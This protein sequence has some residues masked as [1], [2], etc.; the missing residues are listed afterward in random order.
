MIVLGIDTATPKAGIA[1]VRSGRTLAS[2]F[3]DGDK[4]HSETLLAS[5]VSLIDKVGITLGE[6]DLL[7]LGLGPGAFTA[8]R[9]GVTTVKALS[10]SLAVPVVGISTLDVLAKGVLGYEGGYKGLVA[11][12]ID[13]RK[14]EVYTALFRA[15]GKGGIERVGDYLNLTPEELFNSIESDI[16]VLGNG[17]SVL[18]ENFKGNI[19]V[20]P[21]EFWDPDPSVL[22]FM[23][24][25]KFMESGGDDPSGIKPL[26]VRRSD[27]EMNR[28]RNV[29]DS[30]KLLY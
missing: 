4:T 9:V 18:G 12:V 23:A 20:A 21:K 2:L 8:L 17:V 7:A 22:S 25:D 27:A 16:L 1:V 29:Y 13:A 11:P 5:L 26:Y 6:I 10:Y 15:N 3:T 30:R 14:G 19:R 28:E 24:I